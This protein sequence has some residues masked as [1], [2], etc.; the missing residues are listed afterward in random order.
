MS[1]PALLDALIVLLGLSGQDLRRWSLDHRGYLLAQVVT[2]RS[3]LDA[4]AHLLER[5]PDLEGS[6]LP[7]EAADEGRGGGLRQRQPDLRLARARAGGGTRRA[8]TPRCG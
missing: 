7:P 5:R 3:E 6:F 4:L 2:G 8:W 1:W